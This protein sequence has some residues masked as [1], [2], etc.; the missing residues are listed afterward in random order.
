MTEDL[1]LAHSYNL[2]RLG[3][4]GDEVRFA[5]D[6]QQCADIAKWAGLL[7]LEKLEAQIVIQKLAANRFGLAFLLIADV[8]QSCVVTLDPVVSHLEHRFSRELVFTGGTRHRL[9]ADSGPDS[10]Y[11]SGPDLGSGLVLDAAEEEGPEEIHGLHVDLAAPVLE[12][13]A[14]SLEPYPRCP[15]VEF[16]PKSEDSDRPASP[17]AVLKDLKSGV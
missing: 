7:S 15:G 10:G 14:L 17:F 2:A 12:E 11:G 16:A 8:T 4:A 6:D 1:P 9:P 3:N 13:F 5:A